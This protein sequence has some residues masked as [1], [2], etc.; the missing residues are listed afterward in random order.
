MSD[1][2]AAPADAP[3]DAPVEQAQAPAENVSTQSTPAPDVSTEV[4]SDD[5][6]WLMRD[7]FKGNSV[8]EIITKQAQAYPE[9]FQKMGKYWGAPKDSDYDTAALKDFGIE[10]DDP[11]L[12]SLKPVLKDIGIS[13]EGLKKLAAG[14]GDALGNMSRK[15]TDDMQKKM[16]PIDV[17]N[18]KA[19]DGWLK[20]QFTADE[21]ARIESW[22]ADPE[23]FRV[24][25][26][27]RALIP[28]RSNAA[29]ST[30]S[31]G[32]NYDTVY[33]IEQEK[34]ENFQKY[35]TDKAYRNDLSRRE[36]DAR[37]REMRH[38]GR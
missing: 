22:M 37:T 15:M 11:I 14:W 34:V 31:L 35:K 7:K 28:G 13:D 2:Q 4:A 27:L 32:G 25:N 26:T 3:V 16:T 8:D 38:N 20:E 29:V 12:D 19:V 21:R 9:L 30:G 1:I 10:A 23:D 36:R 18:V 5:M 6:P 33:S 17:Q 24:L